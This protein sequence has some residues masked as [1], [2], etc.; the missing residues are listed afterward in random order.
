MTY[1]IFIINKDNIDYD[2]DG[3]RVK[4]VTFFFKYSY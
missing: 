1:N 4:L 3:F 2:F